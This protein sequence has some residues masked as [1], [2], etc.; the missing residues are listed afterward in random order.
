MGNQRLAEDQGTLLGSSTASLN[1]DKVLL[2]A[3]VMGEASHGGDS[4]GGQIKL[5]GGAIGVSSL[6]NAV[7]LLVHLSTMMETVLPSTGNGEHY[8]SRMPCSNTGNLAETLVRLA[9][10]L[11]SSPTGSDTLEALTTGNTDDV[12]VLVLLKELGDVDLLLKVA[13]GP[14]DLVRDTSSVKLDF[15]QVSLL[16]AGAGAAGQAVNKRA[17]NSAVLLNALKLRLDALAI[18]GAVLFGVL[19]ESLALAAI[20]VLIE[21]TADII[22][23]VLSPH[24]SQRAK[25]TRGLDVSNQPNNDHGRSLNNGDGLDDFFLVHLASGTLQIADNVGHSGLEADEGSK[26]DWLLFIVPRES[27]NTAELAAGAL[28]G[29]ETER[30]VTRSFKFTVRLHENE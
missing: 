18:L 27:L 13:I 9:R 20:P 14:V 30:T 24:S 15:Q 21:A 5:S 10:E 22:T 25:P 29:Q 8:T 17:H 4:L 12:D 11:A 6:G 19:G 23:Q 3:S 2:D 28:A 26:M 7:H 16:L 1:H